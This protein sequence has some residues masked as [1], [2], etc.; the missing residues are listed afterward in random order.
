MRRIFVSN[1][2][3]A[4]D[5]PQALESGDRAETSEGERSCMSD[6]DGDTS[7]IREQTPRHAGSG[8]SNPVGQEAPLRAVGTATRTSPSHPIGDGI[9]GG[10][11]RSTIRHPR[12]AII[13]GLSCGASLLSNPR[14]NDLA[15]DLRRLAHARPWL[16]AVET[17]Q[18]TARDR[19]A[20]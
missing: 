3:R 10:A 4:R 17:P 8:R 5:C 7:S 2:R 1:A 9:R 6:Q 15:C 11:W 16:L 12:G 13:R 20:A 14:S 19:I 18:V